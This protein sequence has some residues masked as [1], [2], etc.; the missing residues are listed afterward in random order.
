MHVVFF[1]ESETP[2]KEWVEKSYSWW[3]D[4]PSLNHTS[5]DPKWQ[6][7]QTKNLLISI[8]YSSETC[9]LPKNV[10][11]FNTAYS[12][13]GRRHP[14]YPGRH[15]AQKAAGH[16]KKIPI[17]AAVRPAHHPQNAKAMTDGAMFFHARSSIYLRTHR[18]RVYACGILKKCVCQRKPTRS[19]MPTQG[20]DE[21]HIRKGSTIDKKC[22]AHPGPQLGM[23]TSLEFRRSGTH[24]WSKNPCS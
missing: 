12:M 13:N 2:C 1:F 17:Q 19:S 9:V 16:P 18:V 20:L 8:A 4:G 11:S 21:F 22:V 7:K 23:T 3:F 15:P 24:T 14:G 5:I 6:G 10:V